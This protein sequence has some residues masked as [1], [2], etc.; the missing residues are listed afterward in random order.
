MRLRGKLAE[1]MAATAPEIYKQYIT[2]DRKG[3][4]ALYVLTLNAIYDIMKA[5]LL[6]YLKFMESLSSIGFVL[7]PYDSCIAN[8]IV[9][10]HQLTVVW[11]VDDLKILH[12]NEN[13]VTRMI[14]WLRKTYEVLFDDRTG[15]MIVHRGRVHEYLGMSL[16][17]TI[18]G[19]VKATIF[20]YIKEMIDDFT[21][22]NPTTKTAPNL[23][24][25]HLFKVDEEAEILDERRAQTFHTYVAK[26][27]LETKRA[28]PDIHT[29]V[30][31]LSTRVMTP[32]EDDWK[33]L[34][35]MINYLRGTLELPL[36]LKASNINIVKW[37]VDGSYGINTDCKI[38]TG[39]TQSLGKGSIIPLSP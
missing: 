18:A 27:L 17:F 33:K 31:F 30:A 28:R 37:W 20:D 3:N 1:L 29:A 25:S 23:A 7:N 21:K 36:T 35:R 4:K 19:Q 26:V 39:G 2:I 12:Q 9:D 5:A 14:T 16:A 13:V 34:L 24:A 38:Q 15:A 22:I 32:D 11:H 8:K 10:R 6:F